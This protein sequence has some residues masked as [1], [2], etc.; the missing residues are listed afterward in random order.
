MEAVGE[1]EPRGGRLLDASSPLRT[2]W[3]GEGWSP[4]TRRAAVIGVTVVYALVFTALHRTAGA[5]LAALSI[6]PAATAGALLG[7]R[8]G[9]TAGLLMV[10]LNAVLVGHVAGWGWL[11]MLQAGA[12]LG[13]VANLVIGVT[14]GWLRDLASRVQWQAREL[15]G[16]R[17]QREALLRAARELAGQT[18]GEQVLATVLREAVALLEGDDGGI[19]RWNP[20]DGSLRQTQSFLPRGSDGTLLDA[21]LSACGRAI[22]E[23]AAVI[24]NDYQSSIGVQT[25]AGR[26][27]A[28]AVAAAPLIYEGRLLGSLSVSRVRT[29]G[30]FTQDDATRLELLASIASATLIGQERARLEGAVLLARTAE[31][32]MSNR[33]TTAVAYAELIA[34]DS[35][36]SPDLRKLAE[37]ALRSAREAAR[38]AQQLREITRL[39]ETEWPGLETTIDLVRST[40]AEQPYDSR[41]SSDSTGRRT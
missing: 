24:V 8:A 41:A 36:L 5:G 19:A 22:R 40:A 18:G 3:F 21:E 35:S 14:I 28:T 33:L 29:P 38:T 39:E 10:P 15:A 6:W 11:G 34:R 16:A 13:S 27:G 9:L 31:H 12:L 2:R 23:Q 32:E 37:S 17:S 26:A 1:I 30:T 4:G 20:S 7:A 25:P